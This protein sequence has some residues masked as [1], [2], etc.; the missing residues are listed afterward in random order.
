[1]IEN[2]ILEIISSNGD[3]NEITDEFRRG[4]DISHLLTLLN[5]ENSELVSI[6]TYILD[7]I[8]FEL[9]NTKDF[10]CRLSELVGHNDPIIRFNVL[11]ALYPA[12]IYDNELARN[13]LGKL[14]HDPN[15]GVRIATQSVTTRL[16]IK[17]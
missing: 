13:I 17:E 5:S 1:M 16:K 7:E 11:G 6:G 15:E 3:L 8:D 2:E 14:K 12:F 9:Y 10:L 4:R